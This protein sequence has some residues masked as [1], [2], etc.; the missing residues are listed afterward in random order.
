MKMGQYIQYPLVGNEVDGVAAIPLGQ[1]P[2]NRGL[3]D[4]WVTVQQAMGVQQNTFGDPQ[5][6]TG[7]LTEVR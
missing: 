1:N 4:L 6:C 7:P 5:W 2:K 3:C